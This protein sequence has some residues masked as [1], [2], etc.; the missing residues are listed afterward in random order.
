MWW[1]TLDMIEAASI[2][3]SIGTLAIAISS[4][5]QMRRNQRDSFFPI[6]SVD[7]VRMDC[8]NHVT[9]RL[10]NYGTGPALNVQMILRSHHAHHRPEISHEGLA[11]SV[12]HV[13]TNESKEFDLIAPIPAPTQTSLILRYQCIRHRHFQGNIPFKNF[14]DTKPTYHDEAYTE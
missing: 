8:P 9:I 14:L 10:R 4:I 6:L 13:A 7:A 1:R 5:Y 3:S 2:V 11:Q 12:I